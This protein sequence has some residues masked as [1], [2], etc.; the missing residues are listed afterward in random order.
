MT[1]S[2]WR[3]ARVFVLV[4][5]LVLLAALPTALAQTGDATPVEAGVPDT[6]PQLPESNTVVEGPL[7]M[8]ASV[9]FKA[10][11]H[12]LMNPVDVVLENT[13]KAF[14]GRLVLST[15]KWVPTTQ[16]FQEVDLPPGSTKRFRFMAYEG[17][18]GEFALRLLD[19]QGNETLRSTFAPTMIRPGDVLLVQWG[20]HPSDFSMIPRDELAARPS[21]RD[22][23]DNAEL[24]QENA[25]LSIELFQEPSPIPSLFFTRLTTAEAPP[26][27]NDWQGVDT[28]LLDL[29]T[30]A[31]FLPPQKA[32]V[33]SFVHLGGHLLLYP[34]LDY[35][36]PNARW[37]D[38]LLVAPL[39]AGSTLADVGMITDFA[40]RF[41]SWKPSM[42]RP[43]RFLNA[44]FAA[45]PPETLPRLV[46][47]G[48]TPLVVS[49]EEGAGRVS[50]MLFQP[51]QLTD[52]TNSA[53]VMAQ[54]LDRC[55][56]T[57]ANESQWYSEPR[58]Q[59]AGLAGNT[60][61]NN[62][63][64]LKASA[65]IGFFTRNWAT[66]SAPQS[67]ND[68]PIS[69][70]I[71]LRKLWAV[72]LT[73]IRT[74]GLALLA[75]LL[76]VMGLTQVILAYRRSFPLLWL[77]LPLCAAGYVMLG[78]PAKIHYQTP[79]RYTEWNVLRLTG[80]DNNA[81]LASD[82]YI[83]NQSRHATPLVLARPESADY[84]FDEMIHAG[85]IGRG[86]SPTV[87]VRQNEAPAVVNIT[88]VDGEVPREFL[89]CGPVTLPGTIDGKLVFSGKDQPLKLTIANH[90]PWPFQAGA[91]YVDSG[92]FTLEYNKLPLIAPGEDATVSI[93]PPQ[94]NFRPELVGTALPH[95]A[96]FTWAN[97]APEP[98]IRQWLPGQVQLLSKSQFIGAS[99]MF[100]SPSTSNVLVPE[101]AL[102]VG[103]LAGFAA[104][105]TIDGHP[106][107]GRKFTLASVPLPI[108]W[109][110]G[111]RPEQSPYGW[112]YR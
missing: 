50:L 52:V 22:M 106:A 42:D 68:L 82:H 21:L 40:E 43:L 78:G 110:P 6:A 84:S 26:K 69:G 102:V 90:T 53:A 101:H 8:Q 11:R 83:V 10:I 73:Y 54:L 85:L 75:F 80:L 95:P 2:W 44:D 98:E 72:P 56:A 107:Q 76:I 48:G 70:P 35:G 79:Y 32:L 39:D 24:L 86:G 88:P 20:G 112:D 74:E 46:T 61:I 57:D 12:D 27:L 4:A 97:A 41:P 23:V 5:G 47:P 3:Q 96:T 58:D 81:W 33:E 25:A 16:Y 100:L 30:Y 99:L 7:T 59:N 89:G 17:F 36:N 104:P 93:D 66:R 29:G 92:I 31:E 60:D 1:A 65:P 67:V 28:L 64:W 51:V 103:S 87:H 111:T 71:A 19:L 108:E 37:E 14:K 15:T 49:R 18:D 77:L 105:V 55:G 91:V 38:P 94:F 109:A 63:I 13:G 9:P 34:A 62:G 45:R